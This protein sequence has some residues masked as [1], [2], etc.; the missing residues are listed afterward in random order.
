[1]LLDADSPLRKLAST[2]GVDV[3][4]IER[5]VRDRGAERVIADLCDAAGVSRAEASRLALEFVA[6]R[7]VDVVTRVDFPVVGERFE[8][9]Q[10]DPRVIDAILGHVRAALRKFESA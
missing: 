1:M 2:Y 4:E 3:D 8:K 5:R 7:V 9:R 10:I 6:P